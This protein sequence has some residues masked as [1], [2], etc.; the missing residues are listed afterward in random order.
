M[1]CNCIQEI[2]KELSGT[3]TK[4][5]IPVSLLLGKL[6]ANRVTISVCKR[7]SKKREKPIRLIPLYCPFCGEA[8]TE[9]ELETEN[10]SN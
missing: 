7:D 6:V 1:A 4:L 3:N 5:D 10:D 9:T 2:D 8:Y